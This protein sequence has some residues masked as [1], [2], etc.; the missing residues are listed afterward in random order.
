MAN[1][2]PSN[3]NPAVKGSPMMG[4]PNNPMASVAEWVEQQNANLQQRMNPTS[5]PDVPMSVPNNNMWQ[6]SG[7]RPPN[8]NSPVT[9]MQGPGPSIAD[10]Q[11]PM[12]MMPGYNPAS[13][14]LQSK[15]PNDKLTPEQL[16][17]REEQLK[18]LRKIQQMLHFDNNMPPNSSMGPGMMPDNMNP[19][20]S[21]MFPPDRMP[22]PGPPGMMGPQ[23]PNSQMNVPPQMMGSPP[24]PNGP[25]PMGQLPPN[26]DNMTPP[27]KDWFKLQ[28]EWAMEKR[29]MQAMPGPGMGMGNP[30]PPPPYMINR[31]MPGHMEP[32]TSPN[33]ALPSPHINPGM[34]G[35][36][37]DPA[38]M[39]PGHRR[40]PF[41]GQP[42]FNGPG[43][44]NVRNFDPMMPGMG[45]RPPG[46]FFKDNMN[47]P[48]KSVP[49]FHR[50][51]NPEP[52]GANELPSVGTP[53]SSG[54]GPNKP[55]PSYAQ[56]QKRKR[57]N[58]DFEE[59]YKKLQPAPSPQQINYL[60]QFEGQELTITK[61]LN[62]AY[63]ETSTSS[64]APHTPSDIYN[65]NQ[66]LKSPMSVPRSATGPG[67]VPGHTGPPSVPGV[68][69]SATPVTST[70]PTM[71]SAP[72]ISSVPGTPQTVVAPPTPTSAPP[73]PG[74]GVT[75][76]LSHYDPQNPMNNQPPT[77]GGSMPPGS[78]HSLSNI[79]SSSLAN[80]A[81][82]VENLS[83]QM[84]QNMMQGGPFHNIQVQ[85]QPNDTNTSQSSSTPPAVSSG[86]VNMPFSSSH[87][88]HSQ[89][90]SVNN[91]FV[92]ATMSIQQLNIQNV[93]NNGFPGGAGGPGGG[94]ASMQVQQMNHE[95]L[96]GQPGMPPPGGPNGVPS[97]SMSM[98]QM[99]QMQQ[100]QGMMGG[101][102]GP[103]PMMHG[104][105]MGNPRRFPS[106]MGGQL[107]GANLPQGP[108]GHSGPMPGGP[109]PQG[110]MSTGPPMSGPQGHMGPQG[111]M[112]C[113]QGPMPGQPGPM[114][115]PGGMSGP[116]MGHSPMSAGSMPQNPMSSSAPNGGPP[117]SSLSP[118][119]RQPST[120]V[121]NANV[122][123]Q[124][125]APN[126]IQ[127]LPANPPSSQPDPS[128]KMSDLDM[129]PRF[130]SPLPAGPMGPGMDMRMPGPGPKMPP[131]MM[132]P[133]MSMGPAGQNSMMAMQQGMMMPASRNG[134]S[135]AQMGGMGPF[136]PPMIGSEMTSMQ[137]QSQQMSMQSAGPMP[138]PPQGMRP[139]GPG[140]GMMPGQPQP[141]YNAQFQQFQHQIYSSRSGP[142]PMMGPGTGGMMGS[143]NMGGSMGGPGM[144]PG[145]GMHPAMND[146]MGGPMPGQPGMGP[147]P[148]RGMMMQPGPGPSMQGHPGMF[149][150]GGM[151]PGG[152]MPG[153]GPQYGNMMQGPPL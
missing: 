28:Q 61:Q 23:G 116:H 68:S 3:T 26:W 99:S 108:M 104:P 15:V 48:P 39:F 20:M 135:P 131:E 56:A 17:R 143:P 69:T 139:D 49:T 41:D 30:G 14:L 138:G 25:M 97:T 70:N 100:T 84:Q 21:G 62:M 1:T 94:G 152:P 8:P 145:S 24:G 121:S 50:A 98:S 55:P 148:P 151:H 87:S 22:G 141:G 105:R 45:E 52:F 142:G 113:P 86:T 32:P 93:G 79:T 83:N 31:R 18:S 16:H 120:P 80:L 110:P 109:V 27:Q 91:T 38:F 114:T 123:I 146:P 9:G 5:T 40:P 102:L 90:P 117:L 42:G 54:S 132:D 144:P 81:K 13:N 124:A 134:P 19:Q 136:S 59:L 85:G 46:M 29:R 82:G 37:N 106:P 115:V 147:G 65:Q 67:S 36:P 7:N 34:P 92:N 44:M 133:R 66:P 119:L 53:T 60:N 75:Q 126:T 89:T 64:P 2:R 95:T 73:T 129:L 71:T 107:P 128:R 58:D 74:S 112:S 6:F 78:K 77:P 96:G 130:P 137:M 103:D 43:G 11:G 150:P 88:S 101:P 63:R 47:M 118:S 140:P 57:S 127:Y 33:G 51:G 111:P 10:F 35:A 153:P 76:R 122:Q 125:K 4:E 12:S 149:G 72:T